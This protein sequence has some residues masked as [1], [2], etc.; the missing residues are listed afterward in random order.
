M[1]KA[2]YAAQS[3]TQY[4]ADNALAVKDRQNDYEQQNEHSVIVQW[5]VPRVFTEIE[6]LSYY[7][8]TVKRRDREQIEQHQNEIDPYH[9]CHNRVE[10]FKR[11]GGLDLIHIYTVLDRDN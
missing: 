6:Y 3:R 10:N 1:E 4:H 7:T 8:E 11:Y 9:D 2:I 5:T